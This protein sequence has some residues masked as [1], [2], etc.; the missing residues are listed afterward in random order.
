MKFEEKFILLLSLFLSK[1]KDNGFYYDIIKQ[2][3]FNIKISIFERL[4]NVYYLL[5]KKCSK[6][7]P[8]LEILFNCTFI[9]NNKTIFSI[10]DEKIKKVKKINI[11]NLNYITKLNSSVYFFTRYYVEGI[12]KNYEEL[13]FDS[14]FGKLFQELLKINI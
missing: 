12:P 3:E 2:N 8:N 5:F 13:L 11:M 4:Y 10:I 7:Y 14:F 9:H 6:K 1:I